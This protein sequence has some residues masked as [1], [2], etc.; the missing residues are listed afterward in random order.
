MGSSSSTQQQQESSGKLKALIDQSSKPVVV[1]S[2]ATCPYCVRAKALLKK[3]NIDFDEHDVD[4]IPDAAAVWSEIE[5]SYS[6]SVPAI[7][8]NKNFIGGCTDL[9]KLQ[10]EGKLRRMVLAS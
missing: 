1:F 10:A 5:K 9:Q 7:W 2:T 3:E 8:I 6:T 4:N